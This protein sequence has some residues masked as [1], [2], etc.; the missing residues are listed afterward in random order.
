[1]PFGSLGNIL[2]YGRRAGGWAIIL[3]ISVLPFESLG[4]MSLLGVFLRIEKS[5]SLKKVVKMKAGW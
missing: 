3:L 4:Q 2:N 5:G 1:M